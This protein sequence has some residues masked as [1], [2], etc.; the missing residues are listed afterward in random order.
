MP[1]FVQNLSI[2]YPLGQIITDQV[3]KKN[4]HSFVRK[5]QLENVKETRSYTYTHTFVYLYARRYEIKKNNL[6]FF[7]EVRKLHSSWHQKW[8]QTEIGFINFSPVMVD[9]VVKNTTNERVWIWWT[10]RS[11]YH[12][13]NLLNF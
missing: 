13:N 1:R 11:H 7:A 8:G 5:I 2:S 10:E 9:A 4:D 3:M 6:Y 12:E